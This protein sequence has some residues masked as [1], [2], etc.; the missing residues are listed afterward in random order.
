MP[1][2]WYINRLKTMSVPEVAFRAGQFWQ[3]RREK[4][5]EQR[6][7]PADKKLLRL[8]ESVLPIGN[9]NFQLQD[10]QIDIFGLPFRFDQPI[11]WHLDIASGKRFP[12]SFAKDINIRTEEFGSA[13]HVWEVNRMQFLPLIAL[14]YRQTKDP[15]YLDQFKRILTS[16]IEDNPYLVGVNWYSNIEINIRLIVWFFC[17]EILDVNQLM[18]QDDDFQ[19]LVQDQWLP[20]IYLHMYYSARNPSKYSSANNHLISEH[21]G[22]FIAA[23]FWQFE[24]SAQ[25]RKHAQ[26]GLEDEILAQHSAEGVNKEEAAEYIQFITDF[27][28]IPLVVGQN[29]GHPFSPT[30]QH[31]LES[32]C[33]YIFHMMD[34]KGNIVYYGDEDDGKVVVLEDNWHHDNFRSILSSGVIIFGNTAWKSLDAGFDSKNA[35]LFGEDGRQQYEA[36]ATTDADNTSRFFLQ[37]G[38]FILRKQDRST[39]KEIFIHFDAAPLGYLSIAAH[40][41]ADALSFVLHVDG[42]PVITDSGTY[43]YHTEPEWRQYF[44]STLAHNTLCIDRQNQAEIA[45]PTMWLNHYQA[46]VLAQETSVEADMILA[47]HNGYRNLGITHQRRLQLDKKA[48]VVSITDQVLM[49]KSQGHEITLP[50]HLHP[51]VKVEEVSPHHFRLLHPQARTVEVIL[52]EFMNCRLHRGST[53]PILGWYSPSF[54]KKEPT[55]VILAAC[56]LDHSYEFDTRIQI[57]NP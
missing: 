50:L 18:A 10:Q 46:E 54:Q 36:V 25:W 1:L 26:Q 7:F 35:I 5:K 20:C 53:D 30:Y 29:T 40:G 51:L 39:E 13:K 49:K 41:H 28:L 23:C 57:M 6:Y 47:R 42:H 34:M 9:L 52:P 27:F 11:D 14:Q 19:A 4:Q 24:E 44:L 15:K 32:I 48:E 8:P 43:T 45:G 22:L 21:A 37:E 55:Q 12:R 2:S 38:H 31:R 56:Q 33:N 3:K 17:W 16:W